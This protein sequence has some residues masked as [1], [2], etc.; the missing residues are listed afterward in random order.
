MSKKKKDK[1][2]D[3]YEKLDLMYLQFKGDPI[4]RKEKKE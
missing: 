4:N 2:I 1:V 3:E